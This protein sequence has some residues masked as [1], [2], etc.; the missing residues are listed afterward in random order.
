M[1]DL[2]EEGEGDRK[3]AQVKRPAPGDPVEVLARVGG[4]EIGGLGALPGGSGKRGAGPY[5]RIH[6]NGRGASG[7]RD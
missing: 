6:I 7:M 1:T 2:R 5:G 4:A 3:G